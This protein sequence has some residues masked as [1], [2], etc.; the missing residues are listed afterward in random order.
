MKGPAKAERGWRAHTVVVVALGLAAS[1]VLAA[2]GSEA[3]GDSG[4]SGGGNSTVTVLESTP[5]FFDLPIHV[6][7]DEFA[8]AN[9]LEIKLVQVQGGGAAGQ[10]FQGGTG[11]IAVTAADIPLRLQ[12]QKAVP[13]GVTVIGS[14]QFTMLYTLTTKTD[15]PI[16]SIAQLKGKK[17]GITGPKSSSELVTRWAMKTKFNMDP[18]EATFVALGSVPTI[19]EAVKKGSVDA[20]ILFSPALEQGLADK[21]VKIIYDFRSFPN[22]Q[23]VFYARSSELAKD[24]AKYQ[25][26][27]K[28]YTAAV[29][30]MQADPDFAFA[31]AKKYYGKNLSDDTLREIL[32]F[33]LKNEWAQTQ[34][35]QAS[36]D[37]TRDVL[38][39]SDSGFT[40]QNIPSFADITKGAPAS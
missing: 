14:N 9:G 37:A 28:A 39:N 29:Q 8:K 26:Y 24:P 17:I 32:A 15:S 20:G 2:C 34:F 7:A 3:S 10:E 4:S 27:M 36:Y 25:K 12:M 40:E 30:K 21:A 38:L 16:T 13:G 35:T 33:Y 6:A 18:K 22:G 1:S 19:L 31:Q 11:D 23:N 5:G